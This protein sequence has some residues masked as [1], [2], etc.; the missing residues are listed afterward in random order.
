MFLKV[1]LSTD[2][3]FGKKVDGLYTFFFFLIPI[4][5]LLLIIFD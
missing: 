1:L 4:T 5:K 2:E 3:I